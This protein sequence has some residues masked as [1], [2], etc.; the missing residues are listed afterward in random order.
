MKRPCDFKTPN[1]I[2]KL[3]FETS[4]KKPTVIDGLLEWITVLS[5]RQNKWVADSWDRHFNS[6]TSQ[7]RHEFLSE[8]SSPRGEFKLGE[9]VYRWI[10]E[11]NP[12][13]PTTRRVCVYS[14]EKTTK[15]LASEWFDKSKM[16][17]DDSKETWSSVITQ[18]QANAIFNACGCEGKVV[19]SFMGGND[20]RFS[21]GIFTKDGV[22]YTWVVNEFADGTNQFKVSING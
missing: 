18:E 6:L 15:Q 16:D 1:E 17:L 4:F 11:D 21:D 13:A 20:R 10:V 19:Y 14:L 2:I 22:N 12:D 5:A 3:F 8:G 7:A 9:R